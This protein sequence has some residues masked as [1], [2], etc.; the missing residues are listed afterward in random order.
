MAIKIFEIHKGH[1]AVGVCLQPITRKDI[2]D[3]EI[4]Q[5]FG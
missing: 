5:R 1:S 4:G 2:R 3:L